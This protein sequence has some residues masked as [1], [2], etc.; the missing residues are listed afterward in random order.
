MH[1]IVAAD[2]S[3]RMHVELYVGGRYYDSES[4]EV[5]PSIHRKVTFDRL[6]Y[7]SDF[8]VS[9]G[10][11]VKVIA[12]IGC[13]EDSRIEQFHVEECNECGL[14][15][16]DYEHGWRDYD[17]DSCYCHELGRLVV[18]VI[19]CSTGE[20]L[21]DAIV[22]VS[23]ADIAKTTHY[24]GY[25]MFTLRSGS[26]TLTVSREGYGEEERSVRV[27]SGE[28]NEVT[29]C[30]GECEEGFG[31]EFRCLGEYVQRQYTYSDCSERWRVVEY[32]PYGCLAGACLPPA[33]KQLSTEQTQD[34]EPKPLIALM[35]N[36]GIEDCKVANFTF[37]IYNI[38]SAD[39]VFNL[40]LT[41]P[42]YDFVFIPASVA[43]LLYTSPSPR[44]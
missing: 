42:A 39:G 40:S 10:V 18:K 15:E 4:L 25:V 35:K 9:S 22:E 7:A 21:A 11:D 17:C 37:D 29:V 28:R 34:E 6:V 27:S 32:C 2:C 23:H 24:N 43:C 38:G 8:P 14:C 44:D 26:Y 5:S 16:C 1:A 3:C 20:A 33:P 13:E 36:Y 19:D 12:K 31:S 41:G 30:L